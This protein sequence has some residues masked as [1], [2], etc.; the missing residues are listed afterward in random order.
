MAHPHRLAVAWMLIVWLQ[1]PA[2]P[3]EAGLGSPAYLPSPE[4]P[5]GWRGDGTGCYPAAHPPTTWSRTQSGTGYRTT[6]IAWATPL[7]GTGVSCPIIV[8]THI[9]LTCEPT[10][11]V[12][13]DKARGRIEWIRSNLECEGLSADER[14]AEPAFVER[15]DP[16]HAELAKANAAVVEALN[17]AQ[18]TAATD[19]YRTFKAIERKR[20]LEKQIQT[21]QLSID[22]KR[23]DRY[24]AQAV[25]GFAGQTAVSDG[26]RVC[27]FFTTGVSVCYDLAGRRLWIARGGGNGSEH[28]NF[29]SPL[30]FAN[31]FV[32]WANE[33][34]SYDAEKGTLL[35]SNPA[36]GNNT[37]GSLFRFQVGG[38]WVAAFQCG[39]FTRLRDGKAIWGDNIFGD[40]VST[41]IVANGVIFASVGYPRNNDGLGMHAFKIPAAIEAKPSSLYQLKVDWSADEIPIDPKRSP[42]DRGYVASPLLVD[43]LLYQITQGGGL[44]VH[45]ANTG[46][47]VYRKVL[48]LKPKTEYWGWAGV[49]ASPTLAGAAIYLMD[50]QGTTIVLKPG[51]EYHALHVN[52]L[53]ETRDG[54]GQE[55]SVSTPI[56]EGTR[57]YYRTPNYL[58]SIGE[59]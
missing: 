38:D 44:T 30:L 28:G 5:V 2:V 49:S 51:R 57:M 52:L 4:H 39:Y 36:K 23:F 43:G 50:N 1:I 47:L 19:A 17:A 53:E 45:D 54:K 9:Y 41:P 6:N 26:K 25:F 35:W 33:M 10:D 58:Y 8:G 14:K 12:C 15:R 24:W 7:P 42:F 16:Q 11:V 3:G 29:A 32:V 48:P 31:Q 46:E 59:H 21:Q 40:S 22:K 27:A 37:Y 56:F 13:L 34:R 18:P 55:Q 20:E